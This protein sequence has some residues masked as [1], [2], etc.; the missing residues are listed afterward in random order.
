MSRAQGTSD[1]NDSC[2]DHNPPAVADSSRSSH[3][4][5]PYRFYPGDTTDLSPRFKSH[6]LVPPIRHSVLGRSYG[7]Y[8]HYERSYSINVFSRR[9][10]E[11]RLRFDLPAK[12][13]DPRDFPRNSRD[14]SPRFRGFFPAIARIF[15]RDSGDFFPRLCRGGMTK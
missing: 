5:Y 14:F 4:R 7:T 10:W 13:S 6:R 2:Q 12:A 8:L 11:P 3:H 15:P 1:R 9:V